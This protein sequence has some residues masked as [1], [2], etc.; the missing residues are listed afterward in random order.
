LGVP[1]LA[2]CP[3]DNELGSDT[4]TG[5]AKS[6]TSGRKEI[7]RNLSEKKKKNRGKEREKRE[8]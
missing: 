6:A 8:A 4:R 1:V 2:I 7:T 3:G 5:S